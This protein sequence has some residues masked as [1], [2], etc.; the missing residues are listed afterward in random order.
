MTT[1]TPTRFHKEATAFGRY[2]HSSMGRAQLRASL[3]THAATFFKAANIGGEQEQGFE[4]SFS[5]LAYSYIKDKSPRLLDYII[6]FQLVDR[7]DDNTKAMGV[8]GFK[9]GDQWLYIPVFFLNGDLKGHELLYIKNRDTFVPM[10]ENWVNYLISRKPHILGEPSPRDTYQL[11]GLPPD[12]HRL[13]IPPS[14]LKYGSYHPQVQDWVKPFLAFVGAAATKADT[15][16]AKHAGLEQRLSL[17]IFLKRAFPLLQGAWELCERY[18]L[19]KAGFERFYGKDFFRKTAQEFKAGRDSLLRPRPEKRA[20][21]PGVRLGGSIIPEATPRHPLQTGALR[22]LTLDPGTLKVAADVGDTKNKVDDEALGAVEHNKELTEEER[23]KLLRD[24]TLVDDDRN[25]EDVSEVYNTQVQLALINPGETGV[26]DVLEKPGTFDEMLVVMHPH[27]NRGRSGFCTV[28]RLSD[29]RNWMNMHASR[30][31]VRAS[32]KPLRPDFKKWFDKLDGVTTPEKNGLYL[33]IGANG[34]GTTPFRIRE[35]YEDEAYQVD[36]KDHATWSLADSPW[37]RDR[38]LNTWHDS[39]EPYISTYDAKLYFNKFPGS[40]LR[41]VQGELSVPK[42]FKVFKLKDPPPP[43]KKDDDGPMMECCGPD[44]EGSAEKPIQPGNLADIQ[45]FINEKTGSLRLQDTGTE[46]WVNTQRLTKS[47]A[48]VSLVRDHGCSEA[49]A[50]LLLQEAARAGAVKQAVAYRIRYAPW[51]KQ[52]APTNNSQLE[53]GPTM[54]GFPSPLMGMERVGPSSYPAIYPQEEWEDIPSMSSNRTDPAI[55][56]PFYQPDQRAMQM[57]QEAANSGQKEIFDTS[58][59]SG[60]L[61]AVRQ[62]SLVDRYLGDLM[63]ALDKIGRILFMF[64]WHSEEF[65]DRYGKQDLPELEDTLRNSFEVL[66]DLVLFL[67]E[68]QVGDG[69]DTLGAGGHVGK[70]EPD[71]EEAA[72][73]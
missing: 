11:G 1:A 33:A 27:T 3:G 18:P 64:Y 48:L 72:R 60:M 12:L 47:A 20:T 25:P 71:I 63:K 43:K 35:T 31:F 6:G 53:G 19:L 13:R 51:V 54:P 8:F 66:G 55:Y 15:V 39:D 26:Y 52:A 17:G 32:P 16:F 41:S 29:P 9:V 34:A 10:K 59:V 45:L 44:S 42:D 30:L 69:L 5:S 56:D 49:D 2:W 68:K 57:A 38:T 37:R 50:C 36:F 40:K 62:D 14:N 4:Q 24:R 22:I 21:S 73:N 67:K 7:N 23:G 58:M 28:V 65:E 61:K 46:V 70:G